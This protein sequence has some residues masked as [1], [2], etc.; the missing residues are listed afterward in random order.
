MLFHR[1]GRTRLG[2]AFSFSNVAAGLRLVAWF[3]RSVTY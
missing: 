3:C 1:K 2:V